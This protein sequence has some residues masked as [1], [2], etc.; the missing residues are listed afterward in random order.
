MVGARGVLVVGGRRPAR[1]TVQT[2]LRRGTD[3]ESSPVGVGTVGA[4][5]LGADG[6]SITG[7]DV[8]M[9]G[10]LTASHGFGELAP[11]GAAG[12]A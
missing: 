9:D 3:L 1:Q 5:L 11:K 8:L 10:G 6:A 4:L 2:V 7:S 12:P